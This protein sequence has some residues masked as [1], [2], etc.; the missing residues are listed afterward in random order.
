M[1]KSVGFLADFDE[2]VG[3]GHLIRCL[4]LAD[5]IKQ[6][7]H[8]VIHSYQTNDLVRQMIDEAG[9]DAGLSYITENGQNQCVKHDALVFDGYRF[10]YGFLDSYAGKTIRI[11][12]FGKVD[13]TF[14]GILNHA[15]KARINTSELPIRKALGLDFAI[16]REPFLQ[17]ASTPK[18][19]G[20]FDKIFI[21]FGG[22]DPSGL[23]LNTIKLIKAHYPSVELHVVMGGMNKDSET[24]YGLS[25]SDQKLAVY[26]GLNATQMID[27]MNSCG[28]GIVP[29]S[30]LLFEAL[31]SSMAV[32]SG[33]YIDNQRMIYDGF[34]SLNCFIDAKSF[35]NDSLLSAIDYAM[36]NQPKPSEVIDGKSPERIRD[37][38][39]SL[40]T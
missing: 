24:I 39:E 5:M 15:P 23:T 18:N 14:D 2:G 6:H 25:E 31:C 40:I 11:D 9:F 35:A 21:S 3:F 10:D 12:D 8:P 38:F 7:L 19:Q 34:S 30:S 22:A 16:L 26:G 4:A 13:W 32:I 28:I 1:K 36:D 33:Y 37:L 20:P 29:S 17:S 27:L